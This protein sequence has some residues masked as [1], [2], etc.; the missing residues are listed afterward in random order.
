MKH[1]YVSEDLHQMIKV[2]SQFNGQTMA[3]Y[4]NSLLYETIAE[5]YADILVLRETAKK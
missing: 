5:T 1:V 2:V 4:V 3:D